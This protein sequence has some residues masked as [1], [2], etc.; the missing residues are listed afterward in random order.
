MTWDM[1][2]SSATFCAV[3][4]DQRPGKTGEVP[5]KK[6]SGYPHPARAAAQVEAE[7]LYYMTYS[8]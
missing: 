5:G 4:C 2:I 1:T 8:L 3:Y 7:G 6:P